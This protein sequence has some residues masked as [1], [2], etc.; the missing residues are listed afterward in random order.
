MT[1]CRVID[2]RNP[3]GPLGGPALVAGTDRFFQLVGRC[4]IPSTARA[5]AVNVA[6]TQ[7]AG[8]GHLTSYPAGS[9]L[10]QVALI[11]YR[12]GQTRANNATLSLGAAEALLIRC[13]QSSGT[14]H[15]ILD[16]NG[17]FQ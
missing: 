14:V 5:V 11:N 6:V 10:P 1:P 4:G 9:S 13:A 8:L 7:P 15:L 17:Y 2:T 12:A 16:V 3:N